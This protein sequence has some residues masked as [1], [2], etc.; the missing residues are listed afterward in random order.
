MGSTAW[1]DRAVQRTHRLMIA[2][3][4]LA[5]VAISAWQRWQVLDATPYP[6]GIDGYFYPVQL[7]ALLA[8]GHLAYPAS[9]LTFWWMAP[10]ALATDPITGA[11]LGAAIGGALVALPAYGVGKRL[12]RA[13]VGA[14][15]VAAAIAASSAGSMYLSLEFVKQ[16]IGITV[17]LAA[18]WAIWA[19]LDPT[20]PPSGGAAREGAL[21]RV[22]P[23][24]GRIAIAIVATIATALAHKL[25]IAMLVGLAA[26]ALIARSRLLGVG[27]A[28]AALAALAVLGDL[29]PR[30]LPSLADL[31]L[32]RRLVGPAH[33]DD[34]ALIAPNVTLEFR[35]EALLGGVAALA[36]AI[37][38]AIERILGER[39]APSDR[40]RRGLAW[41]IALAGL[42]I[43][44]PW[45][46]VDDPQG[47][48]FRLRVAAYAPLALSAA[49]VAGALPLPRP[50]SDLALA[51]AAAILFA[52]GMSGDRTEGEVTT[53]AVLADAVARAA[54]H[55]PPGATI[56]VPERHILFMA[57]W[58]TGAPVSLRP[59][60]VP[61]AQRVRLFGLAFIG[62]AGAPLDAA[63]DAARADPTI[64]APPLG[65]HALHR[66]G[67][68]LV[69]EPTWDWLMAHVPA[70]TRAHFT[71]WPT[72]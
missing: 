42:A 21:A 9:P 59:E 66:N 51:I 48:G 26:P 62:G 71:A 70:D 35:H 64:G 22:R 45:L 54:G 13:S 52:L 63:L 1:H 7:R 40:V 29:A 68:V 72:L 11:K 19:A 10:F 41:T 53:P 6:V 33:V 16:G 65:L 34:P 55:I 3:A 58:Y 44:L 8:T 24:A 18:L 60:P 46:R 32:L 31:D 36:A 38:L 2:A 15:L 43:A 4:L 56:V 61:Y 39:D 47:L 5:M 37:A 27:L 69:A 28:I 67:L 20:A 57:R 23:S 17:A 14:G 49:I 12:G 30:R 50:R 25:A